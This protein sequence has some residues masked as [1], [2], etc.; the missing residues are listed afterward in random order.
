MNPDGYTCFGC[1]QPG[2]VKADCPQRRPAPRAKPPARE[3]TGDV[4]WCGQCDQ[5]TRLVALDPDQTVM[6]RCRHCHP[7]AARLAQFRPCLSC[8]QVVYVWDTYACGHHI[9]TGRHL[10]GQ[11]S[12]P[13]PVLAEPADLLAMLGTTTG[14]AMRAQIAFRDMLADLHDPIPRRA[15]TAADPAAAAARDT[16]ARELALRQVDQ[17]RCPQARKAITAAARTDEQIPAVTAGTPGTG[18]ADGKAA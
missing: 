2:H 9:V 5:N 6:T 12:P 18:R 11:P 15:L 10:T 3:E 17:A 4:P 7:H 8:G 16:Q 13:Q 1:G 14:A